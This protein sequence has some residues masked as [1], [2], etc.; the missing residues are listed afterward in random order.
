MSQI[1]YIAFLR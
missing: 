1:Y